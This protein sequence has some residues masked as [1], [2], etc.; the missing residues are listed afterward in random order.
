MIEYSSDVLEKETSTFVKELF[1][2]KAELERKREKEGERDRDRIF[3]PPVHAP[4][5]SGA[6]C[7]LPHVCSGPRT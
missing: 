1:M 4:K 6:S 5:G 3:H 2:C 7:C